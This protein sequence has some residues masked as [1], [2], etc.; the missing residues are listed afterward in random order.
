MDSNLE[1]NVF[2]MALEVPTSEIHDDSE[3]RVWGRCS[4]RE[5]G[6]LIHADRAGHPSV[7]SFFN[8]DETKLEYNA[9]EP[10]HDRERWTDQFVHLMG[11]TGNYTREEAIAAID[12]DRI[13]PDMLVFDPSKPAQY[14]TAASSPTMSSTTGSRS[15]R[16]ATS[17]PPGSS[18]TPTFSTSSPTSATR[19]RRR[20]SEVARAAPAWRQP[21]TVRPRPDGARGGHRCRATTPLAATPR[22][23]RDHGVRPC[24]TVG[25]FAGKWL[26][27]RGLAAGR[28][29]PRRGQAQID[30][31]SAAPV[32]AAPRPATMLATAFAAAKKRAPSSASRSVS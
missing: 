30:W 17:R 10:V 27:S 19:T 5:N 20:R 11:H 21:T 31:A 14:P 28:R 2:S 18:R 8:T 22:P 23:R 15:S 25:T 12:A 4:W 9:S 26:P 7:S 29:P 3:I 16:R 1:A 13:L 6:R 24:V 32:K